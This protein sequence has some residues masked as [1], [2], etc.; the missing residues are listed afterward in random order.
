MNIPQALQK[1]T[2]LYQSEK[3]AEADGRRAPA[4]PRELIAGRAEGPVEFRAGRYGRD[5]H[6]P[7]GS[8]SFDGVV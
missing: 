3:F 2:Q 7:A 5:A 6:V 8:R 4:T 1:V